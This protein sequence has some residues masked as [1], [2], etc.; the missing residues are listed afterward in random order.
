MLSGES[1]LFMLLIVGVVME[2]ALGVFATFESRLEA[3][4]FGAD[5]VGENEELDKAA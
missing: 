2:A 4:E 5:A 3:R 1:F